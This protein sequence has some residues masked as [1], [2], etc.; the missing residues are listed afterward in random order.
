MSAE[1]S[2]VVEDAEGGSG[3]FN[4]NES[5]E[6]DP[7]DELEGTLSIFVLANKSPNNCRIVTSRDW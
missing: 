1:E 4:S 6:P 2:V 5:A 7:I 3:S